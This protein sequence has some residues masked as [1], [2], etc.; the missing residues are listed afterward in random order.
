[1]NINA[2]TVQATPADFTLTARCP[3]CGHNS[4]FE[5]LTGIQDLYVHANIWYGIRRCPSNTCRNLLFYIRSNLEVIATFPFLRIDFD[6][7]GIPNKVLSALEEAITCHANKCYI[8][9]AIMIRKTLDL[10]CIDRGATGNNLKERISS[11]K[12]KIVIPVDLLHGMDD[13]RLLGNDA[14]HI[15]SNVFDDVGKQEVEVGIEF[16]KEIL[17]AVYQY[18]SLLAKLKSLKKRP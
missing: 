16:T 3:G 2:H 1:M 4:T 14:A 13:L 18:S 15:D 7:T 5:S 12:D 6:K 10:I 8:A 9:S 11:L 17:K